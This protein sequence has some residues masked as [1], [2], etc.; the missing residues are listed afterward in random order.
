[1]G[2]ILDNL[3]N[4][5]LSYTTRQPRLSIS[6]ASEGGRALVRVAD[7][8]AG[9]PERERERVFE[10]FHRSSDPAF[11]HVTGTGL[12]LFIGRQLAEAHGGS[13]TIERSTPDE[14]TVFA[15]AL[16]VSSAEPARILELSSDSSKPPI[17]IEEQ[18][19]AASPA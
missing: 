19:A 2:R 8:G 14:G 18:T 17:R 12:G 4:N 7:N 6:V 3:I 9:I 16:P 15:L 11:R 5:G 10:R 13:L 1:L